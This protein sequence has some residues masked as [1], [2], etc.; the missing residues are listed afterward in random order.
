[1]PKKF[2]K[3]NWIIA[4]LRRASYRWPG[5]YEAERLARKDRGQYECNSCKGIFKRG[6]YVLDH[7][8]P[9]IPVDKGFTTWDDYIERMFCDVSNFQLLCKVCHDSKSTTE[10]ELR[11]NYRKKN[12]NGRKT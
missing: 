3:K 12:K 10:K 6:Q 9:V 1:M 8:E 7:I 2:N 4:T 5:R 11:K